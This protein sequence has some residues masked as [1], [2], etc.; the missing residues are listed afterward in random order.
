MPYVSKTIKIRTDQE[1]WLK[2]HPG[3]N[4]SKWARDQFD[5]H[6]AARG[7]ISN[8]PKIPAIIVAAG[9][10]ERLASL[11]KDK[12]KTMLDIKGKTI[13]ERQL[14]IL[15]EAG[16]Q[17]VAIVRGYLGE[18]IGFPGITYYDNRD[19]RDNYILAS[20]FCAEAEMEKGFVFLYSD[21]IFNQ[22]IL[23]E[24][25]RDDTDICVVVDRMW[26]EH[27]RDR[28]EDTAQ[29]AELVELGEGG[30]TIKKIGRNIDPESAYGE[31]IGL[32]RFSPKGAE[33]L[34]NSYH[35]NR[36][37]YADRAFHGSPSIEK[38]SLA[39]M[40]QQL[41]DEGTTVNLIS[42]DRG[43]LEIDTFEDYRQAWAEI[44]G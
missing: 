13:L 12:P 7:H 29:E 22:G 35:A 3:L 14:E 1:R 38:A 10:E 2:K 26:R 32:A 43:W 9:F 23:I 36:E 40:L 21:I 39:E 44:E 15:E 33:L 5:K 4:F 16:I 31:F 41:I 19:F 37:L 18:K 34:R 42:I 30:R 28:L 8:S 17:K 25:L 20:L 27:Y 6:I 24:L 11:I